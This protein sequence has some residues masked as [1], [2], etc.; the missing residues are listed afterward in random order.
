M[1][2]SIK[3]I[4]PGLIHIQFDSQYDLTSTMIRFQEFYESSYKQ[5]RGKY[6]TLE[7]YMDIYAQEHGNFTYFSDWSG[8]NI[9][10]KVFLNAWRT[11]T[12]NL[13]DKEMVLCHAV[14]QFNY[15]Y[16]I[17]TVKGC[18]FDTV[19]H[20]IMHGFY[21]LDSS[22]RKSV[23]KLVKELSPEAKQRWFN[24]LQGKGYAKKVWIDELHAYAIDFMNRPP[25]VLDPY[26]YTQRDKDICGK[27][28]VNAQVMKSKLNLK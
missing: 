6:F 3:E 23:N 5:I 11:F 20:E 8:F 22:Y 25:K 13:R 16:I 4:Y 14:S 21:Y 2:F 19:S 1:K 28:W 10:D 9:P 26:C 7:A 17:A 18:K 27:L 15:G 12:G 24:F